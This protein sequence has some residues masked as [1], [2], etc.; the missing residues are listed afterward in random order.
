MGC[1]LC[2]ME[3]RQNNDIRFAREGQRPIKDFSEIGDVGNKISDENNFDDESQYTYTFLEQKLNEKYSIPQ[4]TLDELKE[5]K[6]R[7]KNELNSR[8]ENINNRDKNKNEYIINTLNIYSNNTIQFG[9]RDK[10]KNEDNNSIFSNF[11]NNK[12]EDNNSS[13]FNNFNNNK[14][15]D[16]KEKEKIIEN[17]PSIRR[18][19]NRSVDKLKNDFRNDNNDDISRDKNS[20]KKKQFLEDRD[21]DNETDNNKD[22]SNNISNNVNDNENNK[23]EDTKKHKHKHKHHSQENSHKHHHKHKHK[24]KSHKNEENEENEQNDENKEN[25]EENLKRDRKEKKSKKRDRKD[26]MSENKSKKKEKKDDETNDDKE[27]VSNNNLSDNYSEKNQN[28]EN[29]F[30]KK[31]KNQDNFENGTNSDN[32]KSISIADIIDNNNDKNNKNKENNKNDEGSEDDKGHGEGIRYTYTK[33]MSK[34]TEKINILLKGIRYSKIDEIIESAPERRKTTL[35]NLIEYF[36]K[37]SKKLSLVERAWLVYKWITL[38]IEYDFAGVNDYNYDITP[39]ATFKRGKSICSG[40]AGL[41]KKIGDNLELTIERIGGFS[42][43]FNFKLGETIE[44]SEKHEW[45]AVQIDGDWF[46]IESTWGAG[47]SSDQATFTKKFNPYYFFTPPQEFVRGHLPFDS[48]WQLLPKPK[49]VSQQTFMAFAPLKSDFFTL[50]FN[51]IDPDFTFNNVKEKGNVKLYFE[52]NIENLAVMGKLYSMTN[53]KDNTEI[54][55][56]ILVIRKKNFFEVNYIINKKGDY[57]IKMFGNDG[58]AKEYNE[59]CTLKLTTEKDASRPLA[60]PLTTALYYKSDMVIIQ[61]DNGI[62]YEGDNIVFEVKSSKFSQLFLGIHSGGAAS[63][64]EM[65]KNGNIFKEEQLVYG[66][67]ILISTKGEKANTY[68]SV[69]EYN[70]LINPKTKIKVTF[71]QVFAGPK[72]KLIEPICDKLKKGKKVNFKIRSELINE[73]AV[74]DQGIQKLEKNGDIFSGSIKI[75]GN[76]DV[77]IVFKKEG[78]DGYGVLYSY[79]VI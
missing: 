17:R 12:N 10:K 6:E 79:K 18:N 48:K 49:K 13:I 52:K 39:E 38:N 21:N 58:S 31:K 7:E 16:E 26:K 11:K 37:N 64:T 73:M 56:S 63:F 40:Y 62:L 50:G 33:Q 23:S 66:Q 29:N 69:L 42:K 36:K 60:F 28:D 41:Y 51:K 14:N 71:P 25:E 5:R 75:S 35:D 61:P 34:N 78:S 30:D 22:N 65:S 57:K 54:P 15:K 46:F 45:N 70:V 76:D 27:N 20:Y 77:K 2:Q 4:K 43:G 3:S 55:N 72:N 9:S 67:K 24:H 53:E 1:E 19:K 74:F 44:D 47:Y 8:R 68:S 32:E 59:L